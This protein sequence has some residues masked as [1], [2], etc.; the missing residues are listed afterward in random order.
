MKVLFLEIDQEREWAVASLGPAFIAAFLRNNGHEADLLRISPEASIGDICKSIVQHAPQLLGLSLTSRQW[1]RA[2]EVVEGIRKSLDVP[3]IAGGLHATF[4]PQTVLNSPGFDYVCLGEGELAM[5][6]LVDTL[7][8]DPTVNATGLRNIQSASQAIVRSGK[9]ELHAPIEPIESLPFMARDMLDERYGVV[10]MTTQRGCPYPCTY[11]AARQFSDLYGSYAAYGRRR[12][13]QNVLDELFEIRTAGELNYVIFLDDTFTI[14]HNWVQEF[15]TSFG[16]RFNVPFSL[17]ARVET[18]NGDMLKRL[19]KAGC[20]HITYGV[21]S[22]SERVRQEI[23]KRQAPNRVFRDTFAATKDAGIL[24]T[25]NYI[26][27][28]PG[29]TRQ[30]IQAFADLTRGVDR[31]HL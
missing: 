28:T 10:H 24:V 31:R 21:E 3:V 27:G 30:D 17:H 8:A 29:E 6:E 4:A 20:A 7:E 18:V 25:A 14:N 11:C 16:E 9:P 13:V 26:L 22:G 1:L 19:A 15:C 5:L 12:S 23:M 2:R